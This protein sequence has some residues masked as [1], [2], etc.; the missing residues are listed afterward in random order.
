MKSGVGSNPGISLLFFSFFFN[1]TQKWRALYMHPRQWV[2]L[3]RHTPNPCIQMQFPLPTPCFNVAINSGVR[4]STIWIN[5]ENGERGKSLVTTPQW[6]YTFGPD[7]RSWIVLSVVTF[8]LFLEV[9]L[10]KSFGVLLPEI[11]KQF[12]TLTWVIGSSISI[13]IYGWGSVIG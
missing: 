12:S 13:I 4:A 11:K 9:G 2:V 1:Q 8:S 5:I 7:C 10:V 6:S 3:W